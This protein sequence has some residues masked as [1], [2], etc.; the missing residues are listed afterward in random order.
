MQFT[1]RYHK[2]DITE[3]IPV[4]RINVVKMLLWKAWWYTPVISIILEAEAGES[5]LQ[6]LPEPHSE[7]KSQA[8]INTSVF[9]QASG[10]RTQATWTSWTSLLLLLLSSSVRLSGLLRTKN[11]RTTESPGPPWSRE[12]HYRHFG[13]VC[14][15]NPS[16]LIER[17]C[18]TLY[19][20]SPSA[21]D[22]ESRSLVWN[23]VLESR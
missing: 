14:F 11:L 17:C 15:C 8:K 18:F 23:K 5:P 4:Q 10:G 6:R 9:K 3:N 1:L 19:A 16:A 22:L 21:W 20:S 2:A 13:T 7:F 12:P